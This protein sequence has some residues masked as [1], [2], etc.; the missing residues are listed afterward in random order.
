[1]FVAIS[2][3]QAQTLDLETVGNRDFCQM[4]NKQAL[5]GNRKKYTISPS[6]LIVTVIDCKFIIY[7]LH[8]PPEVQ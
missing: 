2:V 5:T 7:N 6:A 3:R 8:N 4:Q 1:M